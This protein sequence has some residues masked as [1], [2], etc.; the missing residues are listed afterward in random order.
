[1]RKKPRIQMRVALMDRPFAHHIA[2]RGESG[3]QIKQLV[4]RLK[5]RGHPFTAPNPDASP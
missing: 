1:M 3:H 5:E 4:V 2:A